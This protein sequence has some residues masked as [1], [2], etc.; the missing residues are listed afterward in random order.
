[1]GRQLTDVAAIRYANQVLALHQAL[2]LLRM[3]Q[4]DPR[5]R[6]DAVVEAIRVL[7]IATEPLR[8]VPRSPVKGRARAARRAEYQRERNREEKIERRMAAG[9]T[10]EVAEVHADSGSKLSPAG[11]D[12]DAADWNPDV[13]AWAADL[14]PIP[15]VGIADLDTDGQPT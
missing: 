4:I 6:P 1:M 8:Y 7:E 9:M 13:E 12:M 3:Y 10:R 15:T 11:F 5:Q 14:P 2:G